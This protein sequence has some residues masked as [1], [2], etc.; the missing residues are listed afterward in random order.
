MSDQAKFTPGPWR[1]DTTGGT[2]GDVRGANGRWVALC[3]G[4]GN[5]DP[6]RAA[7]KAECDANANLI[8]AAPE[9]LAALQ[10][11]LNVLHAAGAMDEARVAQDAISRA[12]GQ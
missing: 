12:L 9:L 10:R 7:Y 4:L 1:R 5:G 2:R 11:A 8:A 3:W 6:Y